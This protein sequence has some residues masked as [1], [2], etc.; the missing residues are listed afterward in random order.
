M[1]CENRV[2]QVIESFVA[3][4]ALV[5]TT[6]WLGVISAFTD[7]PF[8]VTGWAGG[9]GG[10]AKF[11]HGLVAFGIVDQGLNVDHARV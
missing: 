1:S 2:G 4:A 6:V 9:A 5:T 8:G 3:R 11:S 10:P 7:D